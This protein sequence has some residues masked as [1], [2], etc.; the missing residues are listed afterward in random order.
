MSGSE[1]FFERNKSLAEMGGGH[2]SIVLEGVTRPYVYNLCKSCA[3]DQEWAHGIGG[4]EG[5]VSL[6][7]KVGRCRRTHLTLTNNSFQT[8][9]GG[10]DTRPCFG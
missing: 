3:V 1:V 2:N 9:A 4:R 6:I 10:R 5:N 8:H 7:E